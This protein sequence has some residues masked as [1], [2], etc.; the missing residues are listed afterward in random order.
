MGFH[1]RE[2]SV[3]GLRVSAFQQALWDCGSAEGRII[4]ADSFSMEAGYS[5]AQK[6]LRQEEHYHLPV[7]VLQT[8]WRWR[9][10]GNS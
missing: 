9:H 6:L 1:E 5:A 8:C 3:S 7:S 2:T 4:K 10:A